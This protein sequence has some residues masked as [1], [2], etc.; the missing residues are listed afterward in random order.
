MKVNVYHASEVPSDIVE[1]IGF[2]YDYYNI[3]VIT[4]SAG[5]IIFWNSDNM[6]PEDA[7]FYRDLSWIPEIIEKAYELGKKQ[8]YDEQLLEAYNA[9]R[10]YIP[11]ELDTFPD[12]KLGPAK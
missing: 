6:E 5:E 7:T 10:D 3:L 8:G 11:V 12:F 4:D 9:S 1:Q 2:T